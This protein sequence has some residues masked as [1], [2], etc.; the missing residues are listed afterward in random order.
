MN[1]PD[2]YF[3]DKLVLLLL[4]LNGFCVLL[5]AALVLLR[6]DN[7]KSGSYIIQYRP[8]QGLSAY[9]AGESTELLAFIVFAAVVFTL[10]LITSLRIYHVR[11]YASIAILAS[12]LLL[13]VLSVIV[14]NA[15]LVL[16]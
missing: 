13:L 6:L 12:G 11:R 16:R 5:T 7:S 8:S 9:K 4:S 2:R 1:S 14:A 3:H 10:H 15:L